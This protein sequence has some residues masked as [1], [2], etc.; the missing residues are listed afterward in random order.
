MFASPSSCSLDGLCI[1]YG[2]LVFGLA[3][4]LGRGSGI[5][6][7]VHCIVEVGNTLELRLGS[8]IVKSRAAV[9]LGLAVAVGGGSRLA[10]KSRHTQAIEQREDTGGVAEVV[11][12]NVDK[13][14]AFSDLS[15]ELPAGRVLVV[16]L[17]PLRT[18]VV[19]L[20]P[21]G[22]L[23]RSEYKSKLVDYSEAK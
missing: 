6:C 3:V 1:V 2:D 16:A 18:K 22:T 7:A 17:R 13:V 15:D 23:P 10:V 19:E 5:A 4:R 21:P 9:Q 12:H 20:V 14:P 8:G 11:V